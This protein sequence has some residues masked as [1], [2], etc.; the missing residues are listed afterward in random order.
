MRVFFVPTGT[1][2]YNRTKEL[3]KNEKKK[4]PNFLCEHIKNEH[5]VVNENG[6]ML[7]S[8]QRPWEAAG[9]KDSERGS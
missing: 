6:W 8:D 3:Q 9:E 5:N 1:P 4:N 7:N 2:S